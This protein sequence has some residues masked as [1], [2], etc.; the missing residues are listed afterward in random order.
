MDSEIVAIIGLLGFMASSATALAWLFRRQRKK[1][2]VSQGAADEH[3]FVIDLWIPA[4]TTAT[5]RMPHQAVTFVCRQLLSAI[6]KQ[7]CL[8]IHA[9]QVVTDGTPDAQVELTV[10]LL[11]EDSRAPAVALTKRRSLFGLPSFNLTVRDG[12]DLPQRLLWGVNTA[13]AL[14]TSERA[15]LAAARLAQLSMRFRD[16]T[17]QWRV[18]RAAF[19]PKP[20]AEGASGTDVA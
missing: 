18:E 15:D 12:D 9:E 20:V 8:S 11:A 5:M 19:A 4:R 6:A 14:A 16:T 2:W 3:C 7:A 13:Y 10:I 1:L 17:A